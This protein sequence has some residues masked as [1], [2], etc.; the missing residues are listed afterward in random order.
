MRAEI[1]KEEIITYLKS[2]YPK[3]FIGEGNSLYDLFLVLKGNFIALK[4][5]TDNKPLT[6]KVVK[7]INDIISAGG[8][9]FVIFNLDDLEDELEKF[10]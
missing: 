8:H 6:Q 4:V 5:K 10:N 9:Y 3:T 1:L 7:A 2:R